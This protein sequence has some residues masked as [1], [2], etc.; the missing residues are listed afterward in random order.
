MRKLLAAF[1]VCCFLLLAFSPAALAHGRDH[2]R[3]RHKHHRQ[4]NHHKHH[5]KH[6]HHDWQR[7]DRHYDCDLDGGEVIIKAHV[8]DDV[9]IVWR[10]PLD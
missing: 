7:H 5:H 8:D 9:T 4:Y 1:T 6:H 3:D 10:V 2:G